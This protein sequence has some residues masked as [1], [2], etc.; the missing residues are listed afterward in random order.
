MAYAANA[1]C[2]MRRMA[3]FGTRGMAI[4]FVGVLLL[5]AIAGCSSPMALM[6]TPNVYAWGNVDPFADVPPALQNNHVDVL[7]VTDRMPEGTSPIGVEYGYKRSR[8]VG[9]G[10]SQVEIG[11]DVSWDELAKASRSSMRLINLPLTVTKTTELGRF[12]PTPRSLIEIRPLTTVPDSPTALLGDI[13]DAA[14]LAAEANFR[15]EL[16]AQLAKTPQKEVYV[17]VHGYNNTFDDSVRTIAELWHFFG[18]QGVPIAYSWPAGSSGLLR[19]YE[20][21]SASSE[22]TVFHLKQMLRVIASCPEVQKV[23]IICHS[24][25]T[26]STINALRELYMEIHASGRD[27]RAVLKLGTLVLAAPDIDI[28]VVIQKILTVRLGQVPERC[29]MYVCGK[30]KA[31]ELSSWLSGGLERLGELKANTFT[32]A[33]LDVLRSS[34]T[35][36]IVDALVTLT[37]FGHDYFHSSPAVSSDLILVMRYHLPPGAENGRPLRVTDNGFWAVDD[38]YP[39]PA[40]KRTD[41]KAGGTAETKDQGSK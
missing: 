2:S 31:L 5:T 41:E 29:V 21:D 16:A 19:G 11:H 7:Y 32:P 20:Y 34:K 17:F 27:T 12:P 9:F 14:E 8:S 24:R 40:E 28:D 23:H 18:R 4:L 36:Q 13:E 35:I 33:E 26:D 25:G 1:I 37:W 30:D 6:P 22:F 10:I 3:I 39:E 15:H 38:S